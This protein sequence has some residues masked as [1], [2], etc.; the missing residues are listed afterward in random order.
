MWPCQSPNQRA[1]RAI[2]DLNTNRIKNFPFDEV[3]D[4]STSE[5]DEVLSTTSFIVEGKGQMEP[6]ED[7]KTA[8]H[9][10]HNSEVIEN[11]F[12]SDSENRNR[13]SKISLTN[14]SAK[15]ST[16][17]TSDEE[18]DENE[19][20]EEDD[21]ASDADVDEN[22]NS[23]LE[24]STG[25]YNPADFEHLV[26]SLEV[27]EMFQYIRRYKPQKIDL[28]TKIRPFI[29]EYIAAVGD[30]DAFLKVP[31]PDGKPDN[32]GL[33]LL[34]EPSTN[35]SD[36][37]VLDLQLRASSKQKSSKEMIVK[38]IEDL[39]ENGKE[40][41]K[42]IRNITNLHLSKPPPAVHYTKPMPDLTS[43]M[44]E[45]PEDFE[46]ALTIAKMPTAVLNC[47]LKEYVEIICAIMDIPVYG[48][49]IESLHLL[50]SLYMEF[51]NS[52]HFQKNEGRKLSK[53]ANSV[54]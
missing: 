37:T 30:T 1:T 5:S 6:M 25:L 2:L 3:V 52:Q 40:I 18:N 28:E 50:F 45:W 7:R 33:T 8:C 39:E 21:V 54:S 32:L 44:S 13:I 11:Y 53:E 17:N 43:L 12:E 51:K 19:S 23:H 42:W 34:D 35:Q 29:P 20:R 14:N 4:V 16:C 46:K 48:N 26:V 41:D 9:T 27:K 36:S 22:E 15:A 47:N 31:R 10:D 49:C 38:S 24:P